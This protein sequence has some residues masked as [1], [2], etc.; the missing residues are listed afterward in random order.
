MHRVAAPLALALAAML[1]APAATAD[2]DLP[3]PPTRQTMASVRGCEVG[4]RVFAPQQHSGAPTVL[5]AHG[6]LRNGDAM[7]G[8]AQAIAAAGMT[9]VTADLCVSAAS[10][11]RPADNAADLVALR[12][13]LGADDVVY[14]GVSAGGLAA[15]IAASQDREATRG[16]LLLDPTNA[17]GQARSAAGRIDAPVAAL[18]ARPQVCNAWRNIDGALRTLRDAT[19]VPMGRASHCDFE[20]PSDRFCRVACIALRA[21]APRE[22]QSRIRA[23]GLGFLD[24]LAD[25]DPAA[26]ARWK[27]AVHDALDPP[28]AAARDDPDADEAP[29]SHRGPR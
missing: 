17:G 10:D 15:L 5:I 28:A 25:R 23:I 11:G 1:A 2:A 12:R 29:P 19:I 24:A 7:R 22:A 13:R 21:D 9:A 27:A 6:F 26:I 18:V 20:W 16:V 14:V 8:W 4:Y 3:A